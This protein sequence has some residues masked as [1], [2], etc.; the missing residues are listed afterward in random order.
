MTERELF[1]TR[2][3]ALEARLDAFVANFEKENSR[4]DEAIER[5]ADRTTHVN[6]TKRLI[7]RVEKIEILTEA[8]N[9]LAFKMR[10]TWAVG[11][12]VVAALIAI[13]IAYVKYMLGI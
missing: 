6:E 3:D 9:D 4:Q 10:I 1:N 11:T 5:L 8:V 7:Q 13:T 12:A 2:F